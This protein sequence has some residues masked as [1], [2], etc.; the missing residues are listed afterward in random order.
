MNYIGAVVKILETPKQ[1]FT[2]SNTLFITFRVQLSQVRKVRIV[3]LVIWG[4]LA[5]SVLNYYKTNDYILI[6]GYVSLQSKMSSNGKKKPLKKV[7][8]TAFKVYPFILEKNR[9]INKLS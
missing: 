5:R 6:E 8:I 3:T 1:K 4:N 2:N 9:L 7:R